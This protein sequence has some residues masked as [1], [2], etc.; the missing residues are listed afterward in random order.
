MNLI[1]LSSSAD[2]P[3]REC[4]YL[5]QFRHW[6]APRFILHF[7]SGPSTRVPP[8]KFSYPS[9]GTRVQ[10]S[11]SRLQHSRRYPQPP[12]LLPS[13]PLHCFLETAGENPPV[14]SLHSLCASRVVV[15]PCTSLER[16]C[17]AFPGW[18]TASA[19]HLTVRWL[20]VEEKACSTC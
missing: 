1:Q 3:V 7:S 19:Q 15:P 16:V 4:N 6:N 9:I 12:T 18:D 13:T 2:L 20:N 17:T 8:P 11:A 5:N 10:Y 14:S